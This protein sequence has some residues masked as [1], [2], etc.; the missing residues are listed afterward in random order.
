MQA[1]YDLNYLRMFRL[2]LEL[3][4]GGSDRSE[5]RQGMDGGRSEEFIG[6]S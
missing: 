6:D 4:P 2:D 3:T 5:M 1:Q